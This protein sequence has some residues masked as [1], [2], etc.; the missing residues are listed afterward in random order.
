MCGI[1]G[2]LD[3]KETGC[4]DPV[5]LDSMVRS[6]AH[7]GPDGSGRYREINFALGHTRLSIIDLKHGS[8][9][10]CNEDRSV[11]ISYNGEIYNFK[12]LKKE[13]EQKGHVFKTECDTEVIIHG[14][15]EWDIQ[16]VDHFNGMFAFALWNSRSQ[17]LFLSRD[18]LGIKPL[19]YCLHDGFF[20]FA[21]EIKALLILPWI[22]SRV[23]LQAIPEYLFCTGILNGKTMFSNIES[24]PPGHSLLVED[25]ELRLI[26]YWDLPIERDAGDSFVL[27]EAAE[28]ILGLMNGSVKRRLMSDVSFGSL[29][30]GGLDS[31][32][33][34]ALASTHTSQPLKTFSMEYSKNAFINKLSSDTKYARLMAEL[35]KTDHKEYIFDPEEYHQIFEQVTRQVEKPIELTTSSLYLLYKHLK[36]DVKVVLSGEGADELFG[37]YFFFLEKNSSDVITEFPWAP[38]YREVSWLLSDDIKRETR[39]DEAINTHLSE[40]SKRYFAHDA[41]NGILRLFIKIYLLEMLER[42]DK[43]SMAWGVE[44]RVP[45]LDHGIV[46][47][48]VNIPSKWKLNGK[49]EKFILKEAGRDLLPSG[50]V[51]R[52]KKPFPFPIDPQSI[53][54]QKKQA[55]ALVQSD[56]SR[57]AH[58]FKKKETDDFFKKRNR[59]KHI[60][61]LAVFRTSHALISLELWHKAFGV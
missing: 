14:Y 48:V 32:F 58:Y 4:M 8:Q 12:E 22:E 33:V 39:F 37:G 6:L 7:R 43:T 31:S 3:I 49:N 19:Y 35:F 1:C 45:F 5:C 15:E 54:R 25:G 40:L 51:E 59:F 27:P 24:L 53:I 34:C 38:Y 44:S 61:N 11:H 46:E 13:L 56:S 17:I 50:I 21:S 55:N 29:L 60:D 20:A 16:C 30:S 18:R 42:Q 41:L 10:M 52:K 26:E 57:I 9:P 36:D 28:S 2:I 47:F 23:N